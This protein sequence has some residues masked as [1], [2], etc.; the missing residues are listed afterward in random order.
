LKIDLKLGRPLTQREKKM[1]VFLALFLFLWVIYLIIGQRLEI[2]RHNNR[3]LKELRMQLAEEQKLH[4]IVSKKNGSQVVEQQKIL[5]E[6]LPGVNWITTFI[7]DMEKWAYANM[8]QIK[9]VQPQRENVNDN[10]ND[11]DVN[12]GGDNAAGLK[13]LPIIIEVEGE[14]YA[15]LNFLKE[16]ELYPRAMEIREVDFTASKGKDINLNENISNQA[17]S[18]VSPLW[19]LT[20]KVNLYYMPFREEAL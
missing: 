20:V 18:R 7:V 9:L 17:G 1:L 12:E 15:L 11:K 16:L 2:L 5:V 3:Q 10:E 8:V 6:R 14:Y 4:P 13:N 19:T